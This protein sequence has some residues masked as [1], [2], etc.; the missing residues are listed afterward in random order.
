MLVKDNS[1][2]FKYATCLLELSLKI[3]EK[4]KDFL[5]HIFEF[6]VSFDRKRY[7]LIYEN[8]Q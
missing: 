7:L 8:L 5:F 4:N 3:G 6:G 1:L 2:W